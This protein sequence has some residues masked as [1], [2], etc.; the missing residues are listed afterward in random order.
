M[1]NAFD[2]FLIRRFRIAFAGAADYAGSGWRASEATARAAATCDIEQEKLLADAGIAKAFFAEG[3]AVIT[4]DERVG[5]DEAAGTA[6]V[7]RNFR[8]VGFCGCVRFRIVLV[9]PIA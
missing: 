5:E 7:P 9:G 3:L 2:T 1:W 4:G 6:V 8:D